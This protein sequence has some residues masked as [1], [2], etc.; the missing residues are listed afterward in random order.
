MSVRSICLVALNYAPERTGIAPYAASLARGLARRGH[1]VSAVVSPPHY[2]EWRVHEGYDRWR[3]HEVEDGVRVTRLRHLVPRRRSLVVRLLSE[4][5]FGL[6]LLATRI[7]ADEVVLVSPALVSSAMLLTK[8]RARSHRP[9]TTAWVQDL[10]SVGVRETGSG[11]R[12]ATWLVSRLEGWFLRS[13]DRVVVIHEGFAE[14]VTALGVDPRRIEVVRNWSHVDVPTVAASEQAGARADLGWGDDEVVVLHAGNQG[15]K[16]G[17]ENVVAAARLADERGLPVR[18]VLMGDG[19]MRA[20]LER[21]AAGVSRIDFVDSLP[22]A[23]FFAALTAAD[24]LLVNELAGVREM[25]VPSKLT[26]YFAAARPVLAATDADSLTA[27]EVAQS[28]GGLRV[29]PGHPDALVDAALYLGRD[30]ETASA[31][32]A[33]GLAFRTSTLSMDGAVG[34]WESLLTTRVQRTPTTA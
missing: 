31:L 32:G 27:Q 24:V 21:A 34:S 11:K 17:L 5:S 19:N 29:D 18:F 3:S 8:L 4:V 30:P 14:T 10:Y 9:R 26:T 28:G 33:S 12:A 15:A 20:D 2:P 6:R 22:D 25:C 23:S 16:Q 13:V 7:R 1:D